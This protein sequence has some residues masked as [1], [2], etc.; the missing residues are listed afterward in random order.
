V[1][2]VI[3]ITL[4]TTATPSNDVA[5]LG[6]QLR[7]AQELAMDAP[8]TS[9]G[10]TPGDA[11]GLVVDVAGA[12]VHPGLHRLPHGARVGDAIGSAGGFAPR[13]DLDEAGRVL[14]LAEPLV[15]GAKV[16]VPELG[17]GRRSRASDTDD[18]IDVNGAGQAE[19]ESLPGIGPVT[20]QKIIDARAER[21]FGSVRELRDRGLVG[22]S[23]FR[24]I[25]PLVRAS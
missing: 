17:M 3:A 13:A 9:E 14:N 22:E 10:A 20:A 4:W 24:D 23:V 15:D 25:E 21:R 7:D 19:L 18:R 12:V 1:A 8:L 11:A 5:G 2:V 16:L 6:E